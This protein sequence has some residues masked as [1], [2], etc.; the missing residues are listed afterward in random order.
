MSA[1]GR[2]VVF[3]IVLPPEREML[4]NAHFFARL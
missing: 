4:I 2:A 3:R 1:G